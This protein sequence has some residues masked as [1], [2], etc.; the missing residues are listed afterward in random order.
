MQS[1]SAR[2]DF[3]II[4]LGAFGWFIV[5]SFISVVWHSPHAMTISNTQLVF[6]LVHELIVLP[7]LAAFLY[8]RGWTV[9]RL[10]IHVSAPETLSGFALAI[11]G[12][13]SAIIAYSIVLAIWPQ[14]AQAMNATTFGAG[15]LSLAA[16]IAVAIVKPIFEEVFVCG[17]VIT[18]LRE[19]RDPWVG[20]HISVATRLLYHLYQGAVATVA[21]VPFG[22]IVALWYARTGRL[23]PDIVAH[24]LMD[25]VALVA[26]V[27]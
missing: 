27:R 17:Y 2:T 26:Y 19:A 20:V 16:V 22:L 25:F 15:K 23:W 13:L 1:F 9:K 5:V 8:V 11:A 14:A 24:G 18:A 4:I 7:L 3:A 12:Y 21:I 6:L 10:G